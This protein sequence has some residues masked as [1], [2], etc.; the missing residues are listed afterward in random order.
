MATTKWNAKNI[1]TQAGKTALITGANSGIG[2]ASAL[3]LADKGAV[4]ILA[5]RSMEKG[6]QAIRQIQK[7]VPDA[8]L[9]LQQL[10]LASLSSI[11]SFSDRIHQAYPQLDLLI[12]NAG[13]M[14]IP[15]KLTEDGFEKQFG[16]NHLGHFALTGLLIDLVFAAE[17]SRVVTVSSIAHLNG[18]INFDDL[19]GEESYNG[20]E[21]YRQSKLANLL[22]TLELA[23]RLEV[24]GLSTISV[25]T[26]PGITH[27][28]L[29]AAG[30]EMR[31]KPVQKWFMKAATVLFAMPSW[32]GA[33]PQLYAATAADVKNGEYFGPD[34]FQ[35]M[36]GYPRRAFRTDTAQDAEL[37]QRLWEISE[38]LTG[39]VYG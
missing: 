31:G 33:L 29:I 26:H 9:D 20:S 39:V 11:H 37:A 17:N 2:F 28:N 32:Q 21:A 12:N 4:V 16:T 19:M 35:E 25:A 34:G 6:E 36:K 1:P 5:C 38:Q 14:N 10:D 13:V 8:K 22:F 15:R 18:A 7:A 3:V 27:T 30:P 23:R 24:K